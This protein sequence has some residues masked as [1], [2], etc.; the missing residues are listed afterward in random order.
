MLEPITFEFLESL[1]FLIDPSSRFAY[2]GD[3][4][5]EKFFDGTMKLVPFR[6]HIPFL[7]ENKLHF[8]YLL[9]KRGFP[10]DKLRKEALFSLQPKIEH[11]KNRLEK[12][13]NVLGFEKTDQTEFDY[14]LLFLREPFYQRKF[15]QV[16]QKKS[17]V[18]YLQAGYIIGFSKISYKDLLTA[19]DLFEELKNT[20]KKQ[21]EGSFTD[22]EKMVLYAKIEEK[23]KQ[24]YSMQ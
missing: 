20:V 3:I 2:L 15:I 21:P 18:S 1:G 23:E 5:V 6:Q 10:M 16:A 24:F 8:M 4:T 12:A 11:Q 13:L 14:P 7:I 22:L 9:E 19:E 17:F